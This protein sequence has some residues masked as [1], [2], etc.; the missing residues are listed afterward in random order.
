MVCVSRMG[1]VLVWRPSL[2]YSESSSERDLGVGG[3]E[4]EAEALRTGLV[5]EVRL[6]LHPVTVGGG[7][8]ALPG[9]VQLR[10]LDEQRFSCGVVHLRYAVGP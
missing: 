2:G 5:D 10:L 1:R 8:P 3:A 9:G 4:L 6:L 7:K